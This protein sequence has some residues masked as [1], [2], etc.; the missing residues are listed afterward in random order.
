MVPEAEIVV[1]Q[2]QAKKGLVARNHQK[3][4]TGK[5]GK[6]RKSYTDFPR[7]SSFF[8]SKRT[9]VSKQLEG[10]WLSG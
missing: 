4:E 8:E 10:I 2:L 5:E 9:Y 6:K 1:M 3:L 7:F